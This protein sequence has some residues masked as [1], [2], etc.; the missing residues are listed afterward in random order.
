MNCATFILCCDLFK[1]F[2]Q[3]ENGATH[4]HIFGKHKYTNHFLYNFILNNS[5]KGAIIFS[6]PEKETLPDLCAFD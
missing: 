1:Q 6:I 2:H 5:S 4:A 3:A